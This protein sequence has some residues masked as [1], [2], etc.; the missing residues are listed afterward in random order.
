MSTFNH[1]PSNKYLVEPIGS[2]F[3]FPD[4]EEFPKRG[5]FSLLGMIACFL[6]SLV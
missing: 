3:L 1:E 5:A 6:T 4:P 2:N